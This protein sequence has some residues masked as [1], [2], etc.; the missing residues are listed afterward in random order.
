M[1]THR[2][3]DPCI[4]HHLSKCW[5]SLLSAAQPRHPDSVTWTS[6]ASLKDSA[7]HSTPIGASILPAVSPIH[8]KP[9]VAA[10]GFRA[11]PE[12]SSAATLG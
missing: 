1:A 10:V 9:T 6:L 8:F 7:D 11:L 4:S 12:A 2:S 3:E 5:H